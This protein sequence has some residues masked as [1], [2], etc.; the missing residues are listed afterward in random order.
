ME[1][2]ASK[3]L[4]PRRDFVFVRPNIPDYQYWDILQVWTVLAGLAC[5]AEGKSV[6]AFCPTRKFAEACYPIAMRELDRRGSTGELAIDPSAI[7]VFRSGL[8]VDERHAVQQ[9]LK[10][11]KV[12][13]VFTTNALEMGI[14]IGGLDGI[15]LAGFPDSMISAWQRIGRAGRNWDADAFVLYF[16]RN[17]PLD[18]FYAA[19]LDVCLNKPLDDLVVNPENEEL[20]EWHLPSLLFETPAMTDSAPVLGQAMERAARKKIASGAKPVRT[21]KWRPHHT[22]N[23]RGGGTGMFLLKRNFRGGESGFLQPS[24]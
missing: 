19:N 22:L 10:T 9:G 5:V 8:A 6:L 2:N 7:R 15:I 1:V 18:R 3:A 23:V 4:R 14:D 12:R 13:L 11:G 16:A 20:V 21:G 24:R 17:N